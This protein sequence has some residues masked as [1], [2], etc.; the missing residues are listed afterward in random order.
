VLGAGAG[1]VNLA[2]G[3]ASDPLAA[4]AGAIAAALAVGVLSYGVSIALYISAAHELGA[5]RA[6]AIFATAPFAGALLSFALLG[7]PVG[8]AHAAA[9]ALLAASVGAL[10]RSRH[11]HVH[12]H[13]ATLHVHSHRH[14]DG[15]HTHAHP[16]LPA[17]TRHS[18][19]HG[20]ERLVHAHP[21]WPD[22]HHRHGHG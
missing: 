5:T 16:E 7:E 10:L 19:A 6:Q 20:H 2:T 14:D 11:A 17:S 18:H 4:P 22:V 15:H 9:A 13:E 1:G 12:V 21:H 3:L 8:V